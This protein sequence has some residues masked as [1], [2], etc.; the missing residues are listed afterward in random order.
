MWE[1]E[2]FVKDITDVKTAMQRLQEYIRTVPKEFNKMSNDEVLKIPAP[3]KWSKQQILGHLIDSAINNLKRFTDIPH[4][5]S[6]YIIK[7]YKQAELVIAN[8]YQHLPLSSLIELWVALN[9]QIV[10][11]VENMPVD[12]H[13]LPVDPQY[14]NREMKDL[15]WVICDY[16]AHME[17]H[18]RQ[19]F[20][21]QS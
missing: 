10:N 3:G 5:P 18:L 12:K 14:D 4:E 20:P 16:V 8:N 15:G 19:I 2:G 1:K 13:R 7:S 21:K 17:H 11:V 9:R 6:P